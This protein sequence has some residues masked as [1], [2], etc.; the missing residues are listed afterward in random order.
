MA[1]EQ[2]RAILAASDLTPATDPVIAGAAALAQQLGAELHVVYALEIE[3]LPPMTAPS[4]PARVKQAEELLADQLRRVAPAVRPASATV[5]HQAAHQAV[6][7]RARAVGA[8][9]IAVGAHRGGDV[10]AHFLGTTAD[11]VIRTAEVPVLVVRGGIPVPLRRMGVATDF[12]GPAHGG[13][14]VALRLADTLLGPDGELVVMHAG[15]DVEQG[16]PAARDG[17]GPRMEA[18]FGEA[19]QRTGVRPA[20]R[21]RTSI[22]WGT[23]PADTI[24]R[25]A[26][27]ERLELLVMGTHGRGGVRRMLTGSVASGVARQAPCSVLLVPPRFGD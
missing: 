18:E 24:A 6:D 11:R 13:M 8:G 5:V 12:S 4:F 22:A 7:E 14:D 21:V 27:D 9:I 23:S 16:E 2:I 15:W 25:H 19:V 3:H 10:G 1:A 26:G 20:A 17:L